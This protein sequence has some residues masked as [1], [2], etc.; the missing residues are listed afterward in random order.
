MLQTFHRGKTSI[1]ALKQLQ[2]TSIDKLPI[3]FRAHWT[4]G[5]VLFLNLKPVF[6]SVEENSILLCP[7]S[8]LA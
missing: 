5:S 8:W 6:L 2:E 7:G 3:S 1:K 4:T